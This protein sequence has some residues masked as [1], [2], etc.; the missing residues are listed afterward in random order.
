MGNGEWGMGNGEWG[1][2]SEYRT[3]EYRISNVEVKKPR[4]GNFG[5]RYSAVR[6]SI[7]VCIWG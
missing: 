2:K 1:I 4:R 5:V 7:F 3:A 6:Y